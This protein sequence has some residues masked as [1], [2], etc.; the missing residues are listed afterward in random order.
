LAKI[1]SFAMIDLRQSAIPTVAVSQFQPS[2]GVSVRFRTSFSL[3]F[4]IRHGPFGDGKSLSHTHFGTKG[5]T[6]TAHGDTYFQ[7]TITP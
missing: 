5:E 1:H 2:T 4:P 6:S 3:L 7:S